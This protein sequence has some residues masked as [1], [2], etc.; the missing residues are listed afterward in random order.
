[1]Q[2]DRTSR[3]SQHKIVCSVAQGVTDYD[4]TAS[5][6]MDE[7][8]APLSDYTS[9]KDIFDDIIERPHSFESEEDVFSWFSDILA[10]SPAANALL[11]EAVRTGWHIGLAALGNSGYHID[12]PSKKLYLD[13]HDMT[14]AALGRSLYFR[15]SALFTFI[16]ALRDIWHEERWSAFEELYTPED[17]LMLERIR[18][19]DCDCVA[20]LSGW[21][22]RGAG[23]TDLWRHLI[24]TCESDMA[25]IFTRFLERDPSGLFNGSALAHAFRQW[26]ADEGRVDGC[27]H[28]VLEHL[29]ELLQVSD[30]RNPF[31]ENKLS[32]ACIE[33]LSELPD[34]MRYLK[35]LGNT[36]RTDPFFVGLSDPIN[37]THLLHLIYDLEVTMAGNVPFQDRDLA[38]RIFPDG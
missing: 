2:T 15:N 24:G 8:I 30:K 20:L 31:G 25:M 22:L 3:K 29:D 35:S 27:D 17:I 32:A 5:D 4:L 26:F 18:A 1:M 14:P 37:Q 36:I 10:D 12:V 6:L 16:K 21:E 13:C 7:N 28:D 38:R 23:Y 9:E 11:T 34:G 19:A 33:A